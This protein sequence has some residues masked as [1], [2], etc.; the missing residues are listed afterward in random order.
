M[1]DHWQRSFVRSIAMR[2]LAGGV[3]AFLTAGVLAATLQVA[4][5]SPPRHGLYDANP[6]HLWNRIHDSF[7]ARVAPDGSEYGFDRIDPLLWRESRHLL[8]GPSHTLAIRLLDE[9]LASNGER[10]VGDPLKRAV[11]QHDLW[12]V[13]DWLA[14]TS[15]GDKAVR[16]VLMRRVVRVMRRV[17]LTRKSIEALP[18]TYAAAATV[19]AFANQPDASK[20]QPSLPRD[21]FSPGGPWVSVGG[22]EPLLPQHA[23]ELG[24]SAFIALWNVPGGSAATIGYLQKLWNF[25]QPFVADDMFQF[26]RDGELRAKL[27]PALP[28]VP[29]GTR[30]ALVRTM[31]LIDDTGAVVPSNVVQSIQLRGFP[32]RTFSEL[33]LSRADLFAG[34]SGGLRSVG[35]DERDFITFSSKGMDPLERTSWH[36]TASLPRV[37]EGCVNCH[38]VG[39]VPGIETVLSLRRMLKPGSHVDSRHERWARWFSQP[40]AAAE[41]KSRSYEWGVFEGLWQ[42]QPR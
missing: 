30:I 32:G 18:D 8:T 39:V 6:N 26:A 9:F 24:R 11:F 22:A 2:S 4:P 14:A 42:S 16:S 36:G 37:I 33:R 25:P 35:T 31:L 10:L 21:L 38:H 41:A 20:L 12:A 28:P 13:F 27:N 3:T 15:S 40:I 19:G 7:Q 23:A 5:A 29:D 34:H 1:P 17:A